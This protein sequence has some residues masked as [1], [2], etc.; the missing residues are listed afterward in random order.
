MGWTAEAEIRSPGHARP[1]AGPGDPERALERHE[2]LRIRRNASRRNPTDVAWNPGGE[3]ERTLGVPTHTPKR[4]VPGLAERLASIRR[5]SGL[6]QQVLATRAGISIPRLRDA[7]RFGTAT[8]ETLNLL[9][10][11]LGT[12]VDVLL[13]RRPGADAGRLNP[14]PAARDG[15]APGMGHGN[16]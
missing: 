4:N 3:R 2:A 9:A 7:E 14:L 10:R 5:A 12:D 11:V 6:S 13:G 16:R 1:L 8:T 15:A